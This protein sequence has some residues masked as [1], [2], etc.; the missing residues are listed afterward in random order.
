[1]E[2]SASS[3]AMLPSFSRQPSSACVLQDAFSLILILGLLSSNCI[4]SS[5]A[6]DFNVLNNGAAGDGITDDTQAFQKAWINACGA[7]GDNPTVVVPQG[8]KFLVKPTVLN[9]PCKLPTIT[10]QVNGEIIAPN[11]PRAW[12]G[13]D[14][15]QWIAFTGVNGLTFSGPGTINGRGLAWWLQSCR[16]HPSLKGCT[17]LAPTAVKFLSCN[18]LSIADLHFVDA[19]QTHVLMM[20]CNSAYVNNLKVKAPGMSPNTD[21]IHLQDVH[22]LTI[23]NSEIRTGDDCISIGDYTS[24]VNITHIDC[25]PGHGISIGSLGK[26]GNVVQVENIH[27]SNVNFTNTTNGARL[28]TWQVGKGFVR[29]ILYENIKVNSVANPIIIDQNYCDK[30]SCKELKTGVKISDVTFRGFT[31][32]SSTIIAVNLQCSRAVACT[33]IVLDNIQLTSNIIKRPVKSSCVNA[34]GT[35]VGM[36]QSLHVLKQGSEDGI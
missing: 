1:M 36:M 22:N 29:G 15:S 13:L 8:K 20:G 12:A 28:K 17:T 19:P 24:N 3:H 23:S 31:G 18:D 30:S 6:A 16:D 14:Q 11:S 4:S 5:K 7:R 32:T 26:A 34:H 27:V 9:G 10:F 33:G 2:I 21:G 25:G 35:T